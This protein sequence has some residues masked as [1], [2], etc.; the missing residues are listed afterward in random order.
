MI[1]TNRFTLKPLTQYDVNDL[2]LSWLTKN[3]TNG[4]IK[5]AKNKLNLKDLKQYVKD[6]ENKGDILFLGI[7]TKDSNQHIGNI[8]YEPIDYA[9]KTATMGILIGDKKWRGKGVANEV[10]TQSAFWLKKKYN[11]TT[12]L[13]SVNTK[14]TVAIMAYKKINF[15]VYQQQNNNIKMSWYL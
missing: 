15:K 4:Y 3:N 14:N 6:R 5:Y 12:I 13:L 11:I 1:K 9:N 8:K 7:F 2:Y 10:I